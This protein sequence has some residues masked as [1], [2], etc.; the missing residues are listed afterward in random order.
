MSKTNYI[1]Y[2]ELL[3]DGS[4]Y[5]INSYGK[6]KRQIKKFFKLIWRNIKK[7]LLILA[8]PLYIILGVSLVVLL[9]ASILGIICGLAMVF[10]KFVFGAIILSS[11]LIVLF[12]VEPLIAKAMDVLEDYI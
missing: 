4:Y 1:N 7:I 5:E 2:Q 6:K 9:F 3:K 12:V 11:S 10:I 8:K